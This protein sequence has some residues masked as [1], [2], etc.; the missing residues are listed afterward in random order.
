LLFPECRNVHLI[1]DVGMIPYI[2]YKYY[3][4]DSKIVCYNNET[5]SSLN[6][7]VKGLKLNFIEKKR[8][9]LK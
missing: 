7:E 8:E 1:K 9:Y 4:Y 6:K 2:L 3:G 5:Y